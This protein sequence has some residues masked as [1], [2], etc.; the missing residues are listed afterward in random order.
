MIKVTD[1]FKIMTNR[2]IVSIKDEDKESFTNSIKYILEQLEYKEYDVF[3]EYLFN[4][5][6]SEVEMNREQKERLMEKIEYDIKS[7]MIAQEEK[8]K[9]KR[10][11]CPYGG[12]DCAWC[13][14][15][16]E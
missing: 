11:E 6:I 4:K 16:C 13:V 3:I 14:E 1:D 8:K 2:A 12:I 9:I 15:D 7:E 10:S 5:I